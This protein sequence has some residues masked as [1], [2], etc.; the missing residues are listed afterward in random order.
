MSTMFV[1]R[2]HIARHA[3]GLHNLQLERDPSHEELAFAI[4]DAPLSQRGFD[5]ALGLGLKFITKES[6]RVGA[7]LCSPLRRTI[8]TSLTAFHRILDVSCYVP[9][10]GRGVQNGVALHLDA[11][12]QEISYVPC[13]NGSDKQN[14][15]SQFPALSVEISSLPQPWPAKTGAFEPTASALRERKK[16]LL[17]K[18]AETAAST[19]P[20]SP[21]ILIVTHDGVIRL[22]APSGVTV[23]VGSWTTLRLVKTASGDLQ[24][25]V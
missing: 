9:E 10:I 11:D 6:N 15:L 19:R 25:T 2:I 8:Q 14:L 13:N 23:D 5:A 3:E 21:D 4:A 18:L 24:L 22:I 12:L 17:L 1:A 20:D 16:R 7:V